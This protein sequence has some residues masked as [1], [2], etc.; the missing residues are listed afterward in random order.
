MKPVAT[1]DLGSARRRSALARGGLARRAALRAARP[2][3][4]G[5]A[6]GRRAAGPLGRGAALGGRAA[7]AG[8]AARAAARSRDRGREALELL[9]G[10]LVGLRR[11]LARRAHGLVELLVGVLALPP[12]ARAQRLDGVLGVVDG[13]LES[14]DRLLGLLAGR[15]GRGLR[16]RRRRPPRTRRALLGR[17]HSLSFLGFPAR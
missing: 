3:G 10:A 1:G 16:A 4:G 17:G 13:P 8:A 14:G 12:E 11:V 15:G 6:L 7:A 5:T 2:L 9:A